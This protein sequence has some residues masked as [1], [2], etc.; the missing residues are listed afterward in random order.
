MHSNAGTHGAGHACVGTRTGHTPAP[1][2]RLKSPA[3]SPSPLPPWQPCSRPPPRRAPSGRW[4]STSVLIL[5]AAD[6]WLAQFR[7]GWSCTYLLGIALLYYWF[8]LS[9]NSVSILSSWI[10]FSSSPSGSRRIV[11]HLSCPISSVVY[12]L[13]IVKTPVCWSIHNFVILYK[14]P[15]FDI[16]QWSWHL[17]V[18]MPSWMLQYFCCILA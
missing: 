9:Y 16:N 6:A 4:F 3:M 13:Y 18:V 8:N 15:A 10:E 7:A 14:S 12:S 1:L 17:H 5:G 11:L 2:S